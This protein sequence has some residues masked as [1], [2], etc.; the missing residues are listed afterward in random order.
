MCECV[1]FYGG[2]ILFVV[3]P[4]FKLRLCR[5]DVGMFFNSVLFYLFYLKAT[6]DD[7]NSD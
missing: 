1:C 3:C 5:E 4:G 6:K 7:E 2:F